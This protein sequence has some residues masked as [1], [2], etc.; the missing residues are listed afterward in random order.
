MSE[1]LL[2]RH[3]QSANNAQA[4]SRR[5]CDPALTPLG[6]QQAALLADYLAN[7]YRVTA[8]YCSPF[9][10][11]LETARPAATKLGVR[12][13]VHAEIFEQGGCYSGYAAV[14]RRGEPGMGAVVLRRRYPGWQLDHRIADEGWWRRDYETQ[15]EARQ[16]AVRV[17]HWL[18]GQHIARGEVHALIIHADFKALLLNELLGQ[19][20]VADWQLQ[21]EWL[22]NVGISHLACYDGH[23]ELL[24]ANDTEYLP[25]DLRSR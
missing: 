25:T 13:F 1:F 9:L 8:L 15:E 20:P 2:I 18:E 14:G 19:Q 12:P 24:R 21:S 16:R 11:S 17:R 3:A 23:W 7:H 4:E 22:F 6:E 10:R 5:V